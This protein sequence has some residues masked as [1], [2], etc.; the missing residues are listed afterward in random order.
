MWRQ[1]IDQLRQENTALQDTISTLEDQ[2]IGYVI[3]T[4][5][6]TK[7]RPFNH[8]IRQVYY[9]FLSKGVSAEIVSYEPSLLH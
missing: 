4:R 7:G 6:D 2:V 5:L 1:E 3:E 8:N 9:E